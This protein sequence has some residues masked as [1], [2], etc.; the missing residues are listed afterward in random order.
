MITFWENRRNGFKPVAR[1][2]TNFSYESGSEKV[3]IPGIV[4]GF[5]GLSILSQNKSTWATF[6]L[7]NVLLSANIP[8]ILE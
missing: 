3:I 7:I 2:S 6:F 8:G 4:I 1:V 5:S